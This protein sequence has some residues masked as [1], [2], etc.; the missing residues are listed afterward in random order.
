MQ[1]NTRT[2]S[3]SSGRVPPITYKVMP[4][5]AKDGSISTAAQNKT[6]PDNPPAWLSITFKIRRETGPA[7]R[8][9]IDEISG[10]V[11]TRLMGS[12][13]YAKEQALTDA[14]SSLGRLRAAVNA[15]VPKGDDFYA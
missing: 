15:E 13:A 2:S 1:L 8:S 14:A 3:S 10:L 12:H 11:G 9:A 6:T 4:S 5:L 7:L